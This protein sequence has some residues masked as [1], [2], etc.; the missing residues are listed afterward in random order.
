M[1]ISITGTVLNPQT[2]VPS[3]FALSFSISGGTLETGGCDSFLMGAQ[4]SGFSGEIGNNNLEIPADFLANVTASPYPTCTSQIYGNLIGGGLTLESKGV[5]FAPGS[6]LTGEIPYYG[7]WQI[8]DAAFTM[9]SVPEPAPLAL[10]M[11]GLVAAGIIR[12][13]AR[14]KR[15]NR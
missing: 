15:A 6:T 9:T 4:I 12:W 11:A 1:Q 13:N 2:D 14:S 3:P 7:Y 5:M 8:R 10:M